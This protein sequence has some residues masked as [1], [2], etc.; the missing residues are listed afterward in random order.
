MYYYAMLNGRGV[1]TS[2]YASRTPLKTSKYLVE[3]NQSDMSK[4]GKM[5][6]ACSTDNV[7]YLNTTQSLS[8]KLEE[9]DTEL[10]A[11]GG[12]IAS[13]VS[14][15]ADV[16]AVAENAEAEAGNNTAAIGSVRVDIQ[17]A[18][19]RMN[20][21]ADQ[22]S[23]VRSIAESA[24]EKGDRLSTELAELSNE[25]VGVEATVGELRDKV[26]T[27]VA[28]LTERANTATDRINTVNERID[29]MQAGFINDLAA[30]NDAI[31]GNSAE[32]ARIDQNVEAV[33]H[34]ANDHE[35]VINSLDGQVDNLT[36][37][38]NDN[39]VAIQELKE[40]KVEAAEGF[41]DVQK[42][43]NNLDGRVTANAGDIAALIGSMNNA[44]SDISAV[45]A[46]VT[47]AFS[48]I[49]A[50]DGAVTKAESSIST[51]AER[52]SATE[53][54]ISDHSNSISSLANRVTKVENRATAV[55]NRAT[56]LEKDVATNKTNITN[57]T[58]KANTNATNIS[59]LTT[60]TSANA[61]NISSL[62]TRTV[63]VEK[64]IDALEDK[65]GDY[66]PITGGT[67]SG[68]LNVDGVIRVN[69]SQAFYYNTDAATMNIG[70]NNATVVNIAGANSGG[71][72]NVNSAMFRPY[73]VIPR[74]SDSLLG[75]TN[76]R[77][78]GI[79][80]QAAV[81]VSSDER[82]KKDIAA[83]DRVELADFI[84]KLPVKTFKYKDDEAL[85]LDRIGL[86]AQDVIKASPSLARYFVSAGGDGYYGLKPAD[87]V[88][89]LIA[90][91][92]QLQDEVNRLKK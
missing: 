17:L 58:T 16:K 74:N 40:F 49:K 56:T 55:E 78:K 3:I 32:I 85:E 6:W 4:V 54:N 60:K 66:L 19:D 90:A 13:L 69:G 12:N 41:L 91:V 77:W 35:S 68:D 65:Q 47:N 15:V 62:T 7:Q 5:Y 25:V 63:A 57:L 59:N 36:E 52:M 73:S 18:K 22:V 50:L 89:P 23:A 26:D 51:L 61:T 44:E 38:T 84:G 21:I 8:D 43:I 24:N 46:R 53:N 28:N 37:A 80:S 30:V 9:I 92:Q 39:T 1:I 76:F 14:E 34:T 86:I 48:D 64:A 11:E 67:V 31:A 88:F 79:Y 29:T 75:N 87:L 27:D 2:T 45:S 81:N 82:L 71:T 83:T 70:T 33:I 20:G 42:D 10:S 72:T